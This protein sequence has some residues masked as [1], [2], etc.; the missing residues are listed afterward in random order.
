MARERRTYFLTGLLIVL[1][2]M[3]TIY[4]IVS[5][6]SFFDNLIGRYLHHF[7]FEYFGGRIPG[8]GILVFLVLVIAVGAVA[9]NLI[10]RRLLVFFER[11]WVKFP[12]VKRVYPAVKQ[13]T[14]FLFGSRMQGKFEKVALLEYPRKGIYSI[15]FVTNETSDEIR[16]K[17][18]GKELLNVLVPSVPSPFTGLL[19]LVPK[20]ELTFLDMGIEDAMKIFLSGGVLNPG[21]MIDGQ[22]LLFED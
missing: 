6:F 5:L 1:P 18:H 12:V 17:A 20:E 13:I 3:V 8:L 15:C 14:R 10:G 7:E 21:D 16:Q 22:P 4:L 9:T 11:F 2:V 19:V